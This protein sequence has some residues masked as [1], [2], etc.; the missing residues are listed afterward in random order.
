MIR[1]TMRFVRQASLAAALLATLSLVACGGGETAE[2]DGPP[3]TPANVRTSAGAN[4]A[5]VAWD[6]DG[7]NVSGF[8]VTRRASAS[9]GG[10]IA[11]E[12]ET[13]EV[14][15]DQRSFA[16]TGLATG[17]SYAY[18]V[19]AVGPAGAS[20]AV[21]ASGGDGDVAIEVGTEMVVGTNDR[22]WDDAGTIF[23]VY[24][25]FPDAVADDPTL[26]F[27]NRID[28]PPG[29]NDGQPYEWTADE[30]SSARTNGWSFVN[31]NPV[32]PVNG[33]YV[34]TLTITGDGDDR[35]YTHEATFDDADFRL[36]AAVDIAFADVGASGFTVSWTPPQETVTTVV[37]LFDTDGDILARESTDADAFSFEEQALGDG[38]YEVQV[39][40]FNFDVVGFPV[41]VDPL[42]LSYRQRTIA[43]GDALSPLCQ[44]STDAVDVPDEALERLLRDELGVPERDGPLTC[45]DLA[46]LD[47]L[48]AEGA[49]I[50]SLDGLEYAANA[51]VLDLG[52]NAITDL[53]PLSGLAD[54]WYLEI[55]GP[56]QA[57][58]DLSAIAGLTGLGELSVN[59]VPLGD[60]QIWPHVESL[61]GLIALDVQDTS[62]SQTDALRS[63]TRLEEL[64]LSDTSVTSVAFVEDLPNLRSLWLSYSDVADLG[65]VLARSD[66]EALALSGLQV[67]DLAFVSSMPSLELLL[68][69]GC[70]VDDFS[71]L[72]THGS[73]RA[74]EAR[75]CGIADVSFVDD[76]PVLDTLA[77]GENPIADF[78]PIEGLEQ[79]VELDLAETGLATVAFLDDFL[80]LELLDVAHNAI[81]DVGALVA[82]SGLAEG[83]DVA[84]EGNLLDLEDPVVAADIQALLD[85]GVE[86]EYEPQQA[87]P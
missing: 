72:A 31:A 54:L 37:T 46:R 87:L 26:A 75:D 71:P 48:G 2:P 76:L 62:V 77:L 43:I 56:D 74:F 18:E 84:I 40:P 41:P 81:T 5:I 69:D 16:D 78:A 28:G 34:H 85:R 38:A 44:G 52:G 29:W 67:A 14:D 15:G 30:T 1:R 39:A 61:T 35:V 47:E 58:A 65:P 33:T 68:V 17:T 8:E 45:G 80:E 22:R 83:D 50:E 63:L 10:L 21:R 11:Q 53:G 64:Q 13:F 66:M 79:L 59:E 12:A 27:E 86:L 25:A 24:Y 42:G 6:H 51:E 49:G 20:S 19:V 73:L 55:D 57:F 60:A 7:R 82:N 32:P 9:T 4:Y 36:G 70:A 3:A 23:V